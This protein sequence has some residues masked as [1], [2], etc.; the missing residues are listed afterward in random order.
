MID[1]EAAVGR[2]LRLLLSPEHDVIA[3]TRAQDGLARLVKGEPFDVIICDLMMPEMSGIEF[4]RQLVQTAPS[5]ARRVVFMTGGAFTSDARDFLSTVG[6]VSLA[7]PF[8]E[9]ELRAVIAS[10]TDAAH[11]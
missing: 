2:A 7:K 1:D 4:Y 6:A 5:Y 11:G 8:T 10:T 3:V 9:Q